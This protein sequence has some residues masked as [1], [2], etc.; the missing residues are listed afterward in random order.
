MSDLDDTADDLV[1]YSEGG[2]APLS[3]EALNLLDVALAT[4]ALAENLRTAA[5]DLGRVDEA[6]R[7]VLRRDLAAKLAEISDLYVEASLA[8]EST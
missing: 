6:A 3:G 8:L 2:P 4:A 7:A 1:P 5:R